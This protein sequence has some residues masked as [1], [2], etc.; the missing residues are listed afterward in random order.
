M[1]I[2]KEEYAKLIEYA[3]KLHLIK[4]DKEMN[5]IKQAMSSPKR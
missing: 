4:S 3:R 1:Y 5:A 2:T